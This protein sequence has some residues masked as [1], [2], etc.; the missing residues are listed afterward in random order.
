M[1][2]TPKLLQITQTAT[3]DAIFKICTEDLWFQCLDI[4]VY[5]NNAY[6]GDIADQQALVLANDIYYTLFPVNLYDFY[7][8]N[9]TAGANT[10]IVAV[11]VL[12][13]DKQIKELGVNSG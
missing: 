6:I 1:Q 8:K 3:S 5:T 4:F 2:L 11:G 7:F 10:K 9:G 12:L 13:S